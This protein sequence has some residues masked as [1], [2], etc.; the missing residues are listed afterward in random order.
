MK[1]LTMS[2]LGNDIGVSAS[3]LSRIQERYTVSSVFI[4]IR[5]RFTTLNLN[6]LP[7]GEGDY[8]T[9]KEGINTLL[10]NQKLILKKLEKNKK[11]LWWL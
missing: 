5:K 2:D 11:W 1:G 4:A 6:W 10:E 8:T 9:K 7:A 3:V